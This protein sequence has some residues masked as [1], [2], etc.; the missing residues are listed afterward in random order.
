M[1]ERLMTQSYALR[2]PAQAGSEKPLL[3]CF[4]HLRWDFVWQR[5]Q[6]LLSRAVKHYDVLIIEEPVFKPGAKPHMDV[7]V[8]PQGVTIAVPVLP[9]GLPHEDVIAEQHDLIED[10]GRDGPDRVLE[11]TGAVARRHD[12]HDAAPSVR[13]IVTGKNGIHLRQSRRHNRG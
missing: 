2:S 13:L 8:R 5:P 9:E 3:V 12:G 10:P 7:S 4:S 1:H 11:R 6:H